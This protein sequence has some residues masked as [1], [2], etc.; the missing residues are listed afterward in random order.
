[1]DTPSSVSLTIRR[2]TSADNRLLAEIGV[3]TFADSFGAQ[4]TPDDMAQYLEL[5]FSPQIQAAELSDPD[6]L[7]LIAEIEGEPV[8]YA[9]LHQ[10]ATPAAIAAVQPIEIVRFY[11]RKAWIGHGIGAALMQACLDEA[12]A[13]GCDV[14]WLDV[15]EENQR[16]RV[17]YEKWGF[18]TAGTQK[19]NLGE[20][21]QNDLLMARR[22]GV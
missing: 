3:E 20:D 18:T 6:S 5:S 12:A 2:A 16:A 1:M 22:V 19:F 7:F 14:V 8:G 4:N 13:R 21:L 15:W 9:R 10:G 11:A 17:F